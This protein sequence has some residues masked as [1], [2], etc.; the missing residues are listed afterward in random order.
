MA[1]ILEQSKELRKIWGGFQG[2]RVLLTANNYRVFDYLKKQKAAAGLAKDIGA[3]KRATEI[4]LDALTG[5]G[6]LKKQKAQYKNSSLASQFLVSG[7]PYYQG[8]II[9]HADTLWQ[10]WSGLD[11]VVKTGKPHHVSHD[12]R[13]FILGMHN[14]A[15][16]KADKVLK[17]VGL[18]GVKE[19]LDLGGGPGT[20]TIEMAKKGISVTIFDTPETIEI[21]KEVIKKSGVKNINFLQGD[22]LADDFGRDYDLIFI[23][24]ILHA[25]SEDDNIM[26][27][28]KCR[29]ALNKNGR[30]VIQE[31][32]IDKDRTHPVQ[33]A[34][35]S[36]NMLANTS[37]G[38]CYSPEE[39]KRWYLKTG[40]R[41]I[42]KQLLADSVLI[43]AEK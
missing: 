34:L 31:F 24:Q 9:R 16:L 32:F 14:L 40:F 13:A 30:I 10:N 22:F 20:Y 21:A 33:A 11:N 36:I 38:R 23:S 18:K 39:V 26:V 29:N 25:Y 1:D 2:A 42:Q 41:K 35:F 17:A 12:H 15:V 37:G 43:S 5:L 7:S 6:L 27:L 28:K 4:L 8:D 19:A 3:D